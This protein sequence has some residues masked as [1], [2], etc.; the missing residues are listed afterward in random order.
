MK[1]VAL[2]GNLGTGKSTVAALFGEHGA[3]LLDADA[4]VHDLLAAGGAAVEAV[5]EAFPEAAAPAGHGIDRRRLA[6][7]VF[8]DDA[9]RRHLERIL[10]PLVVE[11]TRDRMA[12]ARR[13]GVDLLVVEIPLLFE[14]E[15]RGT[16]PPVR[17]RFD[18]VVAVTCDPAVSWERLRSRHA[19]PGGELSPEVE[20]ELRGRLA[21]QMS[22]D[23]KR[24]RADAVIDN[25]GSREATAEQVRMVVS[26][27][28]GIRRGPT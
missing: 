2:T 15:E 10:H 25:S 27:L 16:S 26:S 20:R 8:R 19:G 13:R 4:I 6:G 18:V 7:V 21:A 28:L 11:E 3:E 9:R 24:A 14:A 1:A 12:D 22:Q 5:A 17:S 23:E